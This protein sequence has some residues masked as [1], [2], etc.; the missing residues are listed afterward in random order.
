MS[1]G[2][3]DL[4]GLVVRDAL[5]GFFQDGD[6]EERLWGERADQWGCE[7]AHGNLENLSEL[8]GYLYV[9]FE[10]DGRIKEKIGESEIP[11]ILE[12]FVLGFWRERVLPKL[13]SNV[14]D[15]K[16]RDVQGV[17]A[18]EKFV[19][20]LYVLERYWASDVRDFGKVTWDL[21]E[22]LLSVG[23]VSSEYSSVL[24]ISI[25]ASIASSS[26]E[27]LRRLEEKRYCQRLQRII[28]RPIAMDS[29]IGAILAL[30]PVLQ[31]PDAIEIQK[32]IWE[33][34]IQQQESSKSREMQT[35][36]MY[37][38]NALIRTS[39]QCMLIGIKNHIIDLAIDGFAAPGIGD[40]SLRLQ[41]LSADVLLF[42]IEKHVAE[43]TDLI[44][45]HG[46]MQKLWAIL[47]RDVDNNLTIDV[48]QVLKA[49]IVTSIDEPVLLVLKQKMIPKLL[50]VLSESP[51]AAK[52]AIIGTLALV[53]TNADDGFCALFCEL[54]AFN[55]IIDC[56]EGISPQ[57][58]FDV[59]QALS[60]IVTRFPTTRD[61]ISIDLVHAL[62]ESLTDIDRLDE[63]LSCF[64][65]ILVS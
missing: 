15:G 49:I 28:A 2:Y 3:K 6:E 7:V 53:L 29:R 45:S 36:V 56:L 8:A 22:C 35:A 11:K 57:G 58:A 42:I 48:C 37:C 23:E 31:A 51:V 59:V 17:C 65:S 46:I 54:D 50:D 13:G 52:E 16:E 43:F 39:E 30:V 12:E 19:C 21:V 25:L 61:H 34:L 62:H 20:A 24:A 4:Q 33:F 41:H 27:N 40:E 55:L 60:Q 9:N 14:I 38:A 1:S 47:D 10:V 64:T 32:R 44:L 26:L 63:A 5:D 18:D